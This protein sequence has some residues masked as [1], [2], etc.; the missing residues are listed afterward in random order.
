VPAALVALHI[1]GATAVWIA[2]L[3]LLV[4]MHVRVAVGRP[5]SVAA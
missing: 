1:A 3:R 2:T 5:L 4:S